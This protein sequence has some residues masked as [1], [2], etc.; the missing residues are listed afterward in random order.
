MDRKINPVRAPMM[1]AI[2]IATRSLDK[3]KSYYSWRQYAT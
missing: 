1:L 2:I 3:T